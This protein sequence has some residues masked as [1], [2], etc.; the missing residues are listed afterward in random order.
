MPVLKELNGE[1]SS[2]TGILQTLNENIVNCA[3]QISFSL[4]AAFENLTVQLESF[5][6][7]IGEIQERLPQL[8]NTEGITKLGDGFN[9]LLGILDSI[10][11]I[12][13]VFDDTGALFAKLGEAAAGTGAS[14]AA[15][16][17]NA[18]GPVLI[19]V[20][21]IA[22]MALTIWGLWENCEE[23]RIYCSTMWEDIKKAFNE[24]WAILFSGWNDTGAPVFE[25]WN[26]ATETVGI[27]FNTLWE[28]IRPVFNNIME[29]A[30][31]IWENY[32]RPLCENIRQGIEN[33]IELVLNL[34]NNVVAPILD[35]VISYFGPVLTNLYNNIID[36]LATVIKSAQGMLNG[37]M[38]MFNGVL[39]FINGIF[40]GDWKR[41]LSGLINIFVGFGNLFITIFET[42]VNFVIDL[43]NM[44]FTS[45]LSGIKGAI[46]A[47]LSAVEWVADFIGFDVNLQIS[48]DVP[49]IPLLTIPRISNVQLAAG[50]FPKQGQMFFAREAGPELVGTIGSRSAVVNNEQIVDSVSQEGIQC[51][52]GGFICRQFRRQ[53]SASC[54]FVSGRQT[55]HL[56][57]REGSKRARTFSRRCGLLIYSV[58]PLKADIVHILT[59]LLVG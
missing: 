50:G 59:L 51:S 40:T 32:L 18:A 8:G 25:A 41:A 31:D 21:A 33:I 42:A 34:W 14:I 10:L 47:I 17:S 3:E 4:G 26:R 45:I 11:S 1:V 28:N 9:N 53:Q 38:D 27:V 55:N 30:G 36:V 49:R 5:S 52:T 39:D 56:S 12:I 48:G 44:L 54:Q 24:G 57:R 16:F 15:A 7:K 13:A 35:L 29:K 46:N 43:F 19:A 58:L 23:F 6:G 37:L 22:A 2:L 20:A